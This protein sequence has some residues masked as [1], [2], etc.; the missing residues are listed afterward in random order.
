[1]SPLSGLIV[2]AVCVAFAIFSWRWGED[3]NRWTA[4]ML[5]FKPPSSR[6][7]RNLRWLGIAT[8]ALFVVLAVLTMTGV[9][10]PD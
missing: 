4:R 5:G 6:R 8:P 7:L 2:I 9:I 10:Q 1:L 3:Y